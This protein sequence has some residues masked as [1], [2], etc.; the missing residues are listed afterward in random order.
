MQAQLAGD[1]SQGSCTLAGVQA[2]SRPQAPASGVLA[3][4]CS[5]VLP[6]PSGPGQHYHLPLFFF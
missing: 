1:V 2:Q 4:P 6:Q 5:K 3:C